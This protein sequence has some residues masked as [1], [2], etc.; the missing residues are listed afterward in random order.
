MIYLLMFIIL[1]KLDA[2]AFMWFLFSV[3]AAD[4]AAIW[5]YRGN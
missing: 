1:L 4:D 2:P 5:I 3:C